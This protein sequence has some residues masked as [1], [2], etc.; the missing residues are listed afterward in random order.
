MGECVCVFWVRAEERR[1]GRGEVSWRLQTAGKFTATSRVVK[2]KIN[3]T[4][5]RRAECGLGTAIQAHCSDHAPTTL[6][7]LTASRGSVGR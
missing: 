2:G 1:G 7:A 5:T 6:M 4:D 3:K